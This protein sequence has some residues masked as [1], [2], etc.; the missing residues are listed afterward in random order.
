MNTWTTEEIEI[1]KANYASAT[2]ARL[3]ELIPNK[4]PYAIYKKAYKMGLRKT[5]EI[6]F[7]N[8]SEARKGEKG[9]NWKGGVKIT[10]AGYRQRLRP[11]HPRADSC[12]YVMEHILVWEE[13]TG[14]PVPKNCCIHHLNGNK[15]DNRIENLCMMQHT[16]HTVFHHTGSKRSPETKTKISKSKGG[17]KHGS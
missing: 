15:A 13:K 5:P 2:N 14:V 6:E 16:A 4:S 11:D 8:R 3:S 10:K 17:K 7:L 9:S 12:G 1:L